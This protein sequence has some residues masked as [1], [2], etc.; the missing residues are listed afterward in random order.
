MNGVLPIRGPPPSSGAPFQGAT[1]PP[2][3]AAGGGAPRVNAVTGTDRLV[4]G[5]DFG[6]TYSG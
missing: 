4:V 6:T 3:E 5:V 1:A 2:T